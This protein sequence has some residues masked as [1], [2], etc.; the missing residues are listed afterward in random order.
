MM[1]D[2]PVSTLKAFIIVI[3]MKIYT[4]Y[5]CGGK[6]FVVV[7]RSHSLTYSLTHLCVS[8]QSRTEKRRKSSKN[9]KSLRVRGWQKFLSLAR[10]L[11]CSPERS[12]ASRGEDS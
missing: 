5:H 2:E 3:V 12:P 7:S 4:F 6:T 10:S 8:L 11:A 9:E 1:K